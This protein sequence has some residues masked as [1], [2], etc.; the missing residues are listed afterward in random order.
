MVITLLYEHGIIYNLDKFYI[1]LCLLP[2]IMLTVVLAVYIYSHVKDKR[3]K[4]MLLI[5]NI[6]ILLYQTSY[7]LFTVSAPQE[8]ELL[9]VIN[10]ICYC[11]LGPVFLIYIQTA[12]RRHLLTSF[13]YI[14]LFLVPVTGIII[15]L[16]DN[17]YPL[18]YTV[19]DIFFVNYGLMFTVIT[20]YNCMCLTAA[21]AL[22][23]GYLHNTGYLQNKNSFKYTAV[24]VTAL[25]VIIIAGIYD[26]LRPGDFSRYL[27]TPLFMFTVQIMFLLAA[28]AAGSFKITYNYEKKILDAIDESL[29]ITDTDNNILY[30][31]KSDFNKT[32][33]TGEARSIERVFAFI[34][35]NIVFDKNII[36]R[37][38]I[39]GLYG[40]PQ[41]ADGEF[42]L[43]LTQ[44]E[45]YTY[46][47]Y[48]LTSGPDHVA[49]KIYTFRNI[50][51]YRSLINLLDE[52]NRELSAKNE[53]LNRH[54]SVS[55]QLIQENER[56]RIITEVS[57]TVGTYLTEIVNILNGDCINTDNTRQEIKEKLDNTVKLARKGIK[58]IR[59]SVSTLKELDIEVDDVQK[60]AVEGEADDDK[61]NYSR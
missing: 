45:Y 27:L 38:N 57:D 50:S 11:L 53:I 20:A 43:D 3:S 40:N 46:S 24:Y 15:L 17:L 7:F 16:T 12:V 2:A 25:L 42:V 61:S 22:L 49:G 4:F 9:T 33:A 10:N 34:D 29:I 52:K 56:S 21:S 35:A 31:N 54:N 51:S 55:R 36:T 60:E 5:L 28:G 44:K 13:A 32:A 37:N 23:I 26:A 6:I 18:F 1:I 19:S 48:P 59:S 14:L 41:Q 8:V 39:R 47:F 30:C 58:K